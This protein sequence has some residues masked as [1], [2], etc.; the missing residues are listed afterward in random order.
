MDSDFRSLPRMVSVDKTQLILGLP[1]SYRYLL[2]RPPRFGK[3]ALLSTLVH[4][5]DLSAAG[6]FAETFGSLAVSTQNAHKIPAHNQHLCVL[7]IFS[8]I[9]VH[10]EDIDEVAVSIKDCITIALM[11]FLSTYQK[12][13]GVEDP[14]K[15]VGENDD[16]LAAVLNLVRDKNHSLFVG[17]DDCDYPILSC[18]FAHRWFHNMHQDF[19]SLKTIVSLLDS[20]FWTPLR[21]AS[22]NVVV[23]LFATATLPVPSPVMRGF[24]EDVSQGEIFHAACG[25]TE[26]EAPRLA[27][28]VDVDISISDLRMC[29]EY[30]FVP[31]PCVH[32]AVFHP[33]RL[34]AHLWHTAHPDRPPLHGDHISFL[35]LDDL[36][37]SL[38]QRSSDPVLASVEGLIDLVAA[39]AVEAVD[40]EADVHVEP[41]S[42]RALYYLGALTQD[43]QAVGTLRVANDVVMEKIHICIDS[44]VEHRYDLDDTVLRSFRAY[45]QDSTPQPLLELLSQVLC[46]QTRRVYGQK[47]EPNLRGVFELV[48]GNVSSGLQLLPRRIEPFASDGVARVEMRDPTDRAGREVELRTL[49]LR[50]M[51][52]AANPNQSDSEPS[53]TALREFHEELMQEKEEVL[54]ARPYTAWSTTRNVMETFLVRNFLETE[55]DIPLF[56]AVGGSRVFVTRR[57]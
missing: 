21:A 11:R 8:G 2:V 10:T 56:L 35:Y 16:L 22:P 23:K 28:A 37:R 15:F 31:A 13:L 27:A 41:R 30:H 36:F 6:S 18:I 54:L 4:F 12:Q 32:P 24:L 14:T 53:G 38:P 43:R 51:W 1:E 34:I 26:E 29:G 42:W 57:L 33:Q 48:F 50:G 46:C 9:Q 47:H 5:Y 55:V 3:S 25:F 17:V 52:H 44:P 40:F 49:T 39:S 20:N 45:A 7:F 19:V